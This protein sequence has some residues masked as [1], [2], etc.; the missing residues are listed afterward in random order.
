MGSLDLEISQTKPSKNSSQKIQCFLAIFWGSS[1]TNRPG[2][3]H[4]DSSQS[5]SWIGSSQGP[6]SCVGP[7]QSWPLARKWTSV[8]LQSHW[9]LLRFPEGYQWEVEMLCLI[10][11]TSY[12]GS[13]CR[14]Y[15]IRATSEQILSQV[16]MQ[17]ASDTASFPGILNKEAK[18]NSA[19]TRILLLTWCVC[20]CF[21]PSIGAPSLILPVL[22]KH[23]LCWCELQQLFH[24][25]YTKFDS[26]LVISCY[27]SYS[28]ILINYNYPLVI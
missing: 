9:A 3:S 17:E 2:T 1:A 28:I 19:R 10:W 22:H 27:I 24:G 15:I 23:Q 4:S 16:L 7:T 13:Y 14:T 25:F 20:V 26:W 12:F 5:M 8:K 11:F 18:K 6:V 21:F